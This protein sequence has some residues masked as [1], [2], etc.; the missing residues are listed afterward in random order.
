MHTRRVSVRTQLRAPAEPSMVVTCK[1]TRQHRQRCKL[2]ND[3]GAGLRNSEILTLAL[4]PR[5]VTPKPYTPSS[6]RPRHR[7][8]RPGPNP[9]VLKTVH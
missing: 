4:N 6:P 1:L 7:H 9:G 8:A 3:A 5:L 2:P